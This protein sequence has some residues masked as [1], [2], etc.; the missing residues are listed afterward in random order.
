MLVFLGLAV[1]FIPVPGDRTTPIRVE[2]RVPG[3]AHAAGFH[4]RTSRSTC[5]VL[6]AILSFRNTP[7]GD[8][9]RVACGGSPARGR[10]H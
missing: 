8:F 6:S 10:L 9:V 1:P 5:A 3:M 4:A 2:F 7:K